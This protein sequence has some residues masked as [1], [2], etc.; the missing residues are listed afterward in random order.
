MCSFPT[1]DKPGK[2]AT[3]LSSPRNTKGK[4]QAK[5]WLSDR[6]TQILR[7]KRPGCLNYQVRKAVNIWITLQNIMLSCRNTS[8][9][10]IYSQNSWAEHSSLIWIVWMHLIAIFAVL[11]SKN[12]CICCNFFF[13][14]FCLFL[15]PLWQRQLIY[16]EFSL[17]FATYIS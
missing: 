1:P 9:S 11:D 17:C 14:C 2:E 3:G 7:K 15:L 6:L 8:E 12:V 5:P 13:V 4:L 16:L 10:Q